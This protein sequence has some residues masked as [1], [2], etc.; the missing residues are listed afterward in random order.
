MAY[1]T[2]KKAVEKLGLHPNTLRR[3]ADQNKI[4]SIRNEG[5]QR[6]F[7]VDS[8]LRTNGNIKTICYC[9]VSS[10]KQS[11]DL[12]RQV[13][14]FQSIY[15]EAEIIKDIASGL[16]FKRKGLQTILER[17]MQGDKLRVVVSHKDRLARFG[18]E[19]IEF[20]IAKN[21]GEILVLDKYVAISKQAELTA[22]LLAILHHFS[23]R[24]HG[25]RSK[26]KKDSSISNSNAEENLSQLVR[27]FQ[28]RLQRD[29]KSCQS[30][31]GNEDEALDGSFKNDI[32]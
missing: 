6:L 4:P 23:C 10:R 11:D 9:R 3:Y 15:K 7:D 31:E 21:G 13:E 30:S 1:L 14:R 25:Q 17:V 28:I 5:K 12:N 26:S 29:S 16:N 22:D 19:I 32:E 27:D 20:L 18:F 2:L 8:Y 24:M